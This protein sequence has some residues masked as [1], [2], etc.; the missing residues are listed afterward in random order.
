MMQLNVNGTEHSVDVTPDTPLL[1]GTACA[2]AASGFTWQPM[3]MTKLFIAYRVRL[4]A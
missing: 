2:L 1:W 4:G 3:A